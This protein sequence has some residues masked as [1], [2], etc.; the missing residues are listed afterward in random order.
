MNSSAHLCIIQEY[1]PKPKLTFHTAKKQNKTKTP[2]SIFWN[3]LDSLNIL[4][5]TYHKP[6]TLSVWECFAFARRHVPFH[7]YKQMALQDRL[8][9]I[10]LQISVILLHRTD[11]C[12][13]IPLI[14]NTVLTGNDIVQYHWL[15]SYALYIEIKSKF[16]IWTR[17]NAQGSTS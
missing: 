10:P 11:K 16:K 4:N 15:V 14:L 13:L 1:L 2:S 8:Q 17:K 9:I 3:F 6:A 7:I 5:L 12:L